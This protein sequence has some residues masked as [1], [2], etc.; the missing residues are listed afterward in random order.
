MVGLFEV[1]VA[2]H[3]AKVPWTVS[4][5]KTMAALIV[6]VAFSADIVF[7]VMLQWFSWTAA[8]C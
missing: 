1:A 2:F 4:S 5:A 7:T 3:M 6:A 8:G